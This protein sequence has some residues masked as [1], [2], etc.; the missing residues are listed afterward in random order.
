MLRLAFINMKNDP[1]IRPAKRTSY[2]LS[3]LVLLGW[4]LAGCSGGKPALHVFSW[5]DYFDPELIRTFEKQH[6]CR[7]VIDAYFSNESMYAKLKAG[8]SGYDMV[9]PSS[10]MAAVMERE[11]ML[12]PVDRSLIPNLKNIDGD[13]LQNRALDKTMSYSVP[14][15]LSNSGLACLKSKVPDFKPSWGMLESEV[16]QGRATLMNDMR[17]TLGAALKYLGYSLNTRNEAEIEEAKKVVL[18]WKA[19]A[20][21]FDSSYYRYGL[22]GGEFILVHG[23]SGDVLQ[24][25]DEN[26]DILYAQPVEGTSIS[27]DDFVILKKTK[28]KAL[29]HAFIDFLHDPANAA[30][31]TAFVFYLCP[32]KSSYAL[33][34]KELRNNTALFV[35]EDILAKSE[36][37]RDLGEDN[38]KYLKAWAEIKAR[39]P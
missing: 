31:N 37:I 13:Y 34:G 5:D 7:V 18:M 14:Y 2:V 24:V 3:V 1:E 32:N 4:V 26:E 38:K 17:E 28:K 33:L 6:N 39:T 35:P 19:K 21:R 12:E 16:I 30:K 9:I 8:F 15:M 29:A 10:Y 23:Y 22:A 20:S 25:M 27:C 36:V 11:G